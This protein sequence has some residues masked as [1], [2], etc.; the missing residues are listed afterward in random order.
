MWC[1]LTIAGVIRP[2]FF[3]EKTATGTVYL[4]MLEN[5]TVSHVPHWYIF[6]QNGAPQWTLVIEFLNEQF[7]GI[8]ISLCGPIPWP[9]Q[10]LILFPHEFHQWAYLKDIIYWTKDLPHLHHRIVDV[11]V[12]IL[13]EMLRNTW[14]ERI[15]VECLPHC[16][17]A[18]VKIYWHKKHLLSFYPF[19][20]KQL[21]CIFTGF[22]DTH[23]LPLLC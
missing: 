23:F 15:L 8:W 10:L 17:V 3:H 11:I 20:F 5:Y 14:A 16:K 4:N 6:L 2:V 18:H 22:E 12:S 7:T 13:P 21:A 1:W 19:H 9:P